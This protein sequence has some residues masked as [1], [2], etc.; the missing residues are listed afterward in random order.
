[1]NTVPGNRILAETFMNF[2]SIFDRLQ[3]YYYHNCT[4]SENSDTFLFKVNEFALEKGAVVQNTLE[5][6]EN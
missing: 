5:D 3:F 6:Y 1:M 4:Y 2:F